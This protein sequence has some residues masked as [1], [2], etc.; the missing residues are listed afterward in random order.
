MVVVA[1]V[2][3]LEASWFFTLVIFTYLPVWIIV[4]F[5]E[6]KL[7][8]GRSSQGKTLT[9]ES[10]RTANEA[11]NNIRTVASLGIEEMLTR[12]YQEQLYLPFKYNLQCIFLNFKRVTQTIPITSRSNIK[13]VFIQAMVFAIAQA[14]VYYI[15]PAS[16]RLGA[17]QVASDPSSHYHANY[18]EIFR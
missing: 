16:F 13:S 4:N 14:V 17:F 5:V 11:I 1:L 2:I 3:S 12:I 7:I 8:L 18:E 15:F 10:S 9:A 6:A